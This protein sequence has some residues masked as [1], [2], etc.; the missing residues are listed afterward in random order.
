MASGGNA[1]SQSATLIIRTLALNEAQVSQWRMI[2]GRE[3]ILGLVLGLVL[4][5]IAFVPAYFLSHYHL[6]GAL[7]VAATI[8]MVVLV[9]TFVGSM[10]PILF[11]SLGMDPALMSNPFI[12]ALSDVGAVTIYYTLVFAL[13]V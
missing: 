2:A 6:T 9:G 12:A 7:T 1:G 8:A 3:V 11:K 5:S 10:L 4:A 13:L